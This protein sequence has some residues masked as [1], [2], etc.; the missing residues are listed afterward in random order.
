MIPV[1]VKNILVMPRRKRKHP[2]R[3]T[4]S[5]PSDQSSYVDKRHC[6]SLNKEN[7]YKVCSTA[8]HENNSN[9]D[10]C[11]DQYNNLE[12]NSSINQGIQYTSM[13]SSP[14]AVF[15]NVP[16]YMSYPPPMMS[17]PLPP[18][19]ISPAIESYFKELC[20][21]MAR[22]ETKLNTLDKIE[23]R[24]DK[25]DTKH[26]K[27]DNEMIQCKERLNKLEESAQFLSDIKDE[28]T[29]LKKKVD[30]L[31]SGIE[32][33][34]SDNKMVRD[35]L[36]DIE[37]DNLKQ[38][39]LFFALEEKFEHVEINDQNKGGATDT[40]NKNSEPVKENEN[41]VDSV[42]NFCENVLK[43]ENAKTAIKIEKA[44]RLGKLNPEAPKPRPI[45]AKFCEMSDREAVR[46][47]SNRLKGSNFGNSPH[48]PK[49]VLENRKN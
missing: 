36:I 41:C 35:K 29:A 37:T 27:L 12:M 1:C 5:S 20:H 9:I 17:T 22:V 10:Q 4:N 32:S 8:Q 45:V 46:S 2:Q 48:Y 40:E 15:Q 6:T 47:V 43:I 49:T 25:M 16:Q 39:L 26:K 34:K 42:L 14:N 38:N 19:P 28:H 44:Y 18:P 31:G 33:T 3:Q 7:N 24:L 21:R 23:D 13:T 30:Q 11:T